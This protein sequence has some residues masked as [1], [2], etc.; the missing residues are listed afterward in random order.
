MRGTSSWSWHMLTGL[1]LVIF[2]GGH[3]IATHLDK[4]LGW[5]NANHE[6]AA[7]DWVNVAS[8]GAH[9]SMSIFYILFLGLALYHGF[10]GLRTIL[11]ELNLSKSLEKAITLILVIAGFGL[12]ALGT[13]AA[14]VFNHVAT[15]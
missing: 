10:Y 7:T 6:R 9:F 3:M 12:F 14:L 13:A 8:R 2:L 5:F 15:V 11:F 4:V 1:I